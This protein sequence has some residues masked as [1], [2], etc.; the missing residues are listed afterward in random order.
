M[1]PWL[2]M[3]VLSQVM[4]GRYCP[5]DNNTLVHNCHNANELYHNYPGC[6]VFCCS[7]LWG[8]CVWVT[9]RARDQYQVS[10]H[11]TLWSLPYPSWKS[12][13][14]MIC[15]SSQQQHI[16]VVFMLMFQ[17]LSLVRRND[18]FL[19]ANMA[20]EFWVAT[21]KTISGTSHN[22]WTLAPSLAPSWWNTLSHVFQ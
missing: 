8:R 2:T 19:F 1:S 14:T 5:C 16:R 21:H 17:V 13:R 7:W 6:L 11:S 12:A 20:R 18:E 3:N 4:F 22:N 9:M 10:G 15:S